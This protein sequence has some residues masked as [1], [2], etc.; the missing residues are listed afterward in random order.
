MGYKYLEKKLEILEREV[1]LYY[2]LFRKE[3]KKISESAMQVSR[4]S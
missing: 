4:G 1:S 3:L 2:L